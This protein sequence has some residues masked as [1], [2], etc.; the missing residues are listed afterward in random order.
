MMRK[1][2]FSNTITKKLV[3]IK[4]RQNNQLYRW[5]DDVINDLK[6]MKKRNW[7]L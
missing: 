7:R 6:E 2:Y 3:N 5:E 4:I 1:L